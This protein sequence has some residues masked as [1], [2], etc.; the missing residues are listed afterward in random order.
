MGNIV[1]NVYGLSELLNYNYDR[2]LIDKLLGNFRNPDNN[3]NKKN[4]RL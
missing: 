3:E 1:R 2:L 4:E